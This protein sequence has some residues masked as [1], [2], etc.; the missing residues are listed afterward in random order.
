MSSQDLIIKKIYIIE[1]IIYSTKHRTR[2]IVIV[3]LL[4]II[5]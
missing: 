1:E 3:L 2:G 4:I 5:Y